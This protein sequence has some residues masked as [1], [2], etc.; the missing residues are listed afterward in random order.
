MCS[1]SSVRH[2]CPSIKR[3]NQMSQKA[4]IANYLMGA[5][6][7]S[8]TDNKCREELANINPVVPVQRRVPKKVETD[9]V[10]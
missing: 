2:N 8:A 10:N 5:S 6:P 9:I 4:D 3:A 1:R 7:A